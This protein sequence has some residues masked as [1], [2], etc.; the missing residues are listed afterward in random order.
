MYESDARFYV[1]VRKSS[2]SRHASAGALIHRQQQF[3]GFLHKPSQPVSTDVNLLCLDEASSVGCNS[4]ETQTRKILLLFGRDRLYGEI[5]ASVWQEEGN[6][7]VLKR[8]Y[9]QIY[10][11]SFL[12]C[13]AETV[14][15]N[16]CKI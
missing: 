1:K 15:L 4:D 12:L 5:L 13:Y 6:F 11:A 2:W 10:P 9:I 14:H 3:I 8:C 7:E 16:I